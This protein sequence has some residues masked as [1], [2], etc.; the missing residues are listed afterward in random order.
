MSIVS[1]NDTS[2]GDW[3]VKGSYTLLEVVANLSFSF[4]L[5]A[6]IG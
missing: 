1:M 4:M 3:T 2:L 6:F 5:C